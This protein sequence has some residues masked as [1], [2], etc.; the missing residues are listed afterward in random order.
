MIG[1]RVAWALPGVVLAQEAYPSRSVGLIVPLPP[2]GTTDA[3]S[4]AFAARMADA[5]GRP[6]VI[7]NRP[8]AGANVAYGFAARQPADGYSGHR[9]RRLQP[10]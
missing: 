8:G 10:C 1:R 6:V 3:I 4:R 2:G 5:L 9:H 7:D